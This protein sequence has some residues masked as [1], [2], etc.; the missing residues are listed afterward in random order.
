MLLAEVFDLELWAGRRGAEAMLPEL[1]RRLVAATHESPR[2]LRFPSG[3][4]VALHGWDGLTIVEVASRWVP[5]GVAG[6]EISTREDQRRKAQEDYDLRTTN[7]GHLSPGETTLVVVNARRW[8]SKDDWIKDLSANG[9]TIAWK[10]V[11]VLDGVGLYDWLN[12]APAVHVWFS[13]AIGKRP[14]EALD[15]GE[16]WLAWANS[17]SPPLSHEILVSDREEQVA[18]IR[19]WFTGG[20][21]LLSLKSDTSDAAVAFF[22]AAVL[23][24]DD[25]FQTSVLARTVLVEDVP[26]W[27]SLSRSPSPLVLVPL[28]RDQ[29]DVIASAFGKGHKV[30]LPLGE[31]DPPQREMITLPPLDSKTLVA[32]LIRLGMGPA[33]AGDLSAR[34]A[35]NVRT[36]RR[37][38]GRIRSQDRP[39]WSV[40]EN[41]RA[42]SFIA[43][44]GSWDDAKESDREAVARIAGREYRAIADVLVRWQYA[45]DSPIERVGT[46]WRVRNR[47][48]AWTWLHR[49]LTESDIEHFVD[50]VPTVVSERDPKWDLPVE[51]RWAATA[52][53]K[54][55]TY[56]EQLRLGLAETIAVIGSFSTD[57][58]L[59]GRLS[60]QDWACIAVRRLLEGGDWERW[61]SLSEYLGLLAEGCPN[62]VLDSIEAGLGGQDPPISRIFTDRDASFFASSPHAGLLWALETVAWSE[63]HAPRAALALARL[64]QLDPGGRLANRPQAS[65]TGIFRIGIPQTSL[66]PT[67]RLAV[68][69]LLRAQFPEAAWE[70]MFQSMPVAM[71]IATQAARPKW[72]QWVPAGADDVSNAEIG[73]QSAAFLDRLVVDSKQDPTRWARLVE[74]LDDVP[75][76]GFNRIV[77]GLT[78]IEPAEFGEEGQ[79][80]LWLK[81]GEI[82][83]RHT[84]FSAAA[85]ALPESAIGEL[86][87]LYGRFAPSGNLERGLPLFAAYPKAPAVQAVEG[88]VDEDQLRASRSDVVSS[89]WTEGGL[90]R[91]FELARRAEAPWTVG[92]AI[93]DAGIPV[94]GQSL[95]ET[96]F[97][98]E[99]NSLMQMA[100]AYGTHRVRLQGDE[101]LWS[102]IRDPFSRSW[103]PVWRA[104]LYMCLAFDSPTWTALEGEID[105]VKGRYWTEVPFYGRGQLSRD[106]VRIVAEHLLHLGLGPRAVAFLGLYSEQA[107]P[108]Q[109]LAALEGLVASG[110]TDETVTAS[111]SHDI[112]ALLAKLQVS[113][114]DQ[115]RVA[116]LEWI[117][118]PFSGPPQYQPLALFARLR[119][120]PGFFV[121]LLTLI[122]RRHSDKETN[123]EPDPARRALA[124]RAFGLLSAWKGLP[125]APSGVATGGGLAEWV[126]VAREKAA[127][128]DRANV[129]DIHIGQVLASGPV[130]AEGPWPSEAVRELIELTKN[131]Q[132]D[133]GFITGA[134]NTRGITMRA[135]GEGG[136]QELDLAFRYRAWAQD[137]RLRWPRTASLLDQVGDAYERLARRE[138]ID[139]KLESRR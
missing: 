18:A 78:E 89:L 6:W 58:L 111:L 48:E 35:G 129:A 51:E 67:E 135:L 4:G 56:S 130:G 97:A 86:T 102:L 12:A 114:V 96:A 34:C 79:R 13:I 126:R 138:D 121:E 7:P 36:L 71:A 133:S 139:A 115:S 84:R 57:S 46:V 20:E 60:A 2:E 99:D 104:Q 80:Q 29:P 136:R 90:D 112:V 8:G 73:P 74:L 124:A 21:Q 11:K 64:T 14:A 44:S 9:K 134:M 131:P 49:Y 76:N 110:Q 26:T 93:V 77:Q 66:G 16:W 128:E 27:R 63:D 61:A 120:D 68:I 62:E 117:A 53:G 3:E 123:E 92:V 40:P 85:W 54:A 10:D 125:E 70:V 30:L 39:Q 43:L 47:E 91:L 50:V 101:W 69:D 75:P 83:S 33:D 132:L 1:L 88:R 103:Q 87:N 106:Q 137:L 105:E 109:T 98:S 24:A 82:V 22:A 59:D 113:E 107:D 17:T 122:Y 45:P 42:L 5:A 41:G 118:M 81:L 95:L 127:A 28:F 100:R 32:E 38:L 31:D 65:L 119:D 108:E 25:E 72:R 116:R 15:L 23:M 19:T 37:E 94:E 55:R 52:H